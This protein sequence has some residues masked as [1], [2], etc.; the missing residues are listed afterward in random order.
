M[1]STSK[2]LRGLPWLDLSLRLKTLHASSGS[3]SQ[4]GLEAGVE[5]ALGH[6]PCSQLCLF[7]SPQQRNLKGVGLR[8]IQAEGSRLEPQIDVQTPSPR[9][10]P[11]L[12]SS[13]AF[14]QQFLLLF[15]VRA[16]WWAL[17]LPLW[18]PIYPFCHVS[19]SYP[20]ARKGKYRQ[21]EELEAE[22]GVGGR[23]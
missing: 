2:R 1:F 17:F 21:G 16:L 19:S 11:Q 18:T 4:P 9:P 13:F 8:L 6:W 3:S 20:L 22:R 7:E 12:W 5:A 15:R 10:H 23:V 14:L